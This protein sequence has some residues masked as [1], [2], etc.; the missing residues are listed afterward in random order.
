MIARDCRP[1]H[2]PDGTVRADRRSRPRTWPAPARSSEEAVRCRAGVP[3][4]GA[5]AAGRPVRASL[6]AAV[7]RAAWPSVPVPAEA[8]RLSQAAE[9]SRAADLQHHA[10][11]GDAV[12][13]VGRRP[14]AVRCH[15]GAVR[16]LPADGP[17]QRAGRAGELWLLRRALALVLGAEA[18]PAHYRRGHA[19]GLV[20]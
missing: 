6:A 16:Y 2:P 3:G 20:P 18:V 19:R 1:R 13:V 8:A 11:P 10:A 7:L 5:G 4:G 14:A 12:P 15:P 9:G 17:P